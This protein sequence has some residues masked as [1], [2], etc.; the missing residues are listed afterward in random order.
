MKNTF[1]A[2][3]CLLAAAAVALLVLS[4]G[5]CQC[6]DHKTP[7]HEH[8]PGPHSGVDAK[9]SPMVGNPAPHS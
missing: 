9:D 5:G 8:N 1:A 3:R 7:V 6:T 2:I 4:L